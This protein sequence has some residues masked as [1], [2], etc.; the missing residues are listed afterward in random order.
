MGYTDLVKLL[1]KDPRVD[2]TEEESLALRVA[3]KKGHVGVVEALIRD[4]RADPSRITNIA[5]GRLDIFLAL[6][7]ART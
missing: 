1:L 7:G 6:G 4:G 3:V 5:H 2:P